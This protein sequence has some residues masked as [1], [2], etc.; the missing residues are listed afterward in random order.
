MTVQ[1]PVSASFAVKLDRE[2]RLGRAFLVYEVD[3]KAHWT[4]VARSINGH[5]GP[6]RISGGGQGSRRRAGRGDQRRVAQEGRQHDQVRA[7]ADRGRAWV[8]H[9]E[10]PRRQRARSAWTRRRRRAPSTALSDGDLTTG[11]GGPGAHTASLAGRTDREPAFLSFYLD[12]P[13][14]GTLTVSAEG[15][16]ARAQRK[17]QV[18]V[19]LDGRPAGW[20]TVPV[21]GVLPASSELRLRVTG[22]R[23]STAQVSEAR[24]LSFP[25]LDVAGGPDGVVPAAR[26]VSRPQDLRA[27]VR[28]RVGPPAEA[29]AL[30]RR[31]AAGGEDRRGRELR[32]ARAGAGGREGQAV[33]HPSRGRRGGRKPPDADGPGRHLRRAA[34][35]PHHRRVAAGRG[36]GRAVRRGRVAREGEHARVRGREDRD[37]GGRGR[38]RRAG[39]D[40]R[41]RPRAGSAGRGGDGQR[42]ARAA[43]PCASARTA[44]SSRSRSR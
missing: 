43:A 13:T 1:G 6:R 24:V 15:G 37:P 35:G 20:Q 7:D 30:R 32:G 39:D 2:P 14:R 10:R 28:L 27:R 31:P 9:P 21:A 42:D 3:K 16:A 19:D 8:Q 38:Q 36:R 5:V 22:D 12:K 25:S 11:V 40:A 23:E 26:R 4:G 18:S 44:S 17:G 41:A 33:E 29:A 34:E